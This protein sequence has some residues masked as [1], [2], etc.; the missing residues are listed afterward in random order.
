MSCIYIDN[1]V[2]KYQN[3]KPKYLINENKKINEQNDD[4]FNLF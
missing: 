4:I 1:K 2:Q 3:E